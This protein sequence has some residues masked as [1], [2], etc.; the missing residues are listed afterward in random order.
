MRQGAVPCDKISAAIVLDLIVIML[1]LSRNRAYVND[2]ECVNTQDEAYFLIEA[3]DK[4]LKR[5]QINFSRQ[6]SVPGAFAS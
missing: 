6:Q 5:L 1:S 4:R 3:V 2:G